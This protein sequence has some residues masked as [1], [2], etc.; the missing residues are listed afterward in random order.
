MS[1]GTESRGFTEPCRQ[2]LPWGSSTTLAPLLAFSGGQSSWEWR[3]S[4]GGGRGI[5]HCHC[6]S[7][8]L[9]CWPHWTSALCAEPFLPVVGPGLT[10]SCLWGLSVCLSVCQ[11]GWQSQLWEQRS[12]TLE[13]GSRENQKRK[14][15]WCL[16]NTVP[17]S[18]AGA[19]FNVLNSE[20]R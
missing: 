12:R 11:K 15:P 16:S 18:K 19:M 6:P 7:S 1:T 17:A 10:S 9:F 14:E 13:A 20:G 8:C 3:E 5:S 2:A 4:W